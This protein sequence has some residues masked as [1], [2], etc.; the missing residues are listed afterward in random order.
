MYVD[1]MDLDLFDIGR[2]ISTGD[3]QQ[4]EVAYTH[5]TMNFN[6]Y[7]PCVNPALL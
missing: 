2:D 1:Q 4:G 5:D 6:A 3:A 7:A